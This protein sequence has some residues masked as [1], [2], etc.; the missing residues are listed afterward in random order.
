VYLHIIHKIFKKKKKKKKRKCP[1]ATD[2]DNYRKAQPIKIA[3]L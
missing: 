1:L 2:G 3:G